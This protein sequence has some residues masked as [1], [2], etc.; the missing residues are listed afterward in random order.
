MFE[1]QDRWRRHP[2]LRMTA[3]KQ[4]FPGFGTAVGIFSV[5]LVVD[6]L[7]KPKAVHGAHHGGGHDDHH[8]KH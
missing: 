2:I 5:Y 3:L 6:W 7:M 1:K 4:L 8:G